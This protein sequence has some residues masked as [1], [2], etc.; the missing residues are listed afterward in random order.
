[1]PAGCADNNT[2]K[3]LACKDMGMDCSFEV[4]HNDVDEVMRS[5][6]DHAKHMHPDKM[7][8]MAKTMNDAQMKQA[9]MGA[10]KNW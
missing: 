1:M 4:K 6:T 5:S 2:M 3:S 10:M 9:M 8:E 7:K